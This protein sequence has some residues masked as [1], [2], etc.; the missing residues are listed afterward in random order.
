MNRLDSH[1]S[2]LDFW[3]EQNEKISKAHEDQPVAFGVGRFAGDTVIYLVWDAATGGF[4]PFAGIKASSYAGKIFTATVADVVI[5][6]LPRSLIAYGNGE[7][8]DDIAKEL[9]YEV[10]FDV[11]GNVAGEAIGNSLGNLAGSARGTRLVNEFLNAAD[12]VGYLKDIAPNDLKLMVSQMDYAS[13]ADVLSHF[14]EK[15]VK[16]VLSG[17]P[18]QSAK[19]IAG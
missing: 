5:K 11:A 1:F 9:T 19:S 2:G 12:K 13:A 15:T 3:K 8:V 18:E 14:S 17:L 10:G 16:D 6:D 7:D 4:G